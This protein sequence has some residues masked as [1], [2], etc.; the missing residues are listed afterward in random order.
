MILLGDLNSSTIH[1]RRSK[2]RRIKLRTLREIASIISK[3]MSSWSPKYFEIRPSQLWNFK[4]F[5][6]G[7]AGCLK[8]TNDNASDTDL[9]KRGGHVPTSDANLAYFVKRGGRVPTLNT[10]LASFVKHGDHILTSDGNHLSCD[11]TR[12]SHFNLK[13]RPCVLYQMQR[14]HCN[15]RQKLVPC[16]KIRRSRFNLKSGPRVLCQT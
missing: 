16:A 14:S 4:K 9:A 1:L 6:G 12:R 5:G 2:S 11:K 3:A 7:S 8:I 10:D 15:L 13:R